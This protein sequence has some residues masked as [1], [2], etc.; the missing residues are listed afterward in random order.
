MLTS[1]EQGPMR[2]ATPKRLPVSLSVSHTQHPMARA[3]QVASQGLLPSRGS[4]PG[5]VLG[6]CVMI[7]LFLVMAMFG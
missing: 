5:Q 7:G 1:D 2:F 3:H 6:A 4:L